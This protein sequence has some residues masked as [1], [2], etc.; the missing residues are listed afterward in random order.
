[1]RRIHIRQQR[2]VVHR[3]AV[4]TRKCRALHCV[5]SEYLPH[6]KHRRKRI[7]EN[8]V[9]HPLRQ[10]GHRDFDA[11]GKAR[12]QSFTLFVNLVLQMR[13][14]RKQRGTVKKIL[15]QVRRHVQR[16]KRKRRDKIHGIVYI[17]TLRIIHRRMLV[18]PA[19]HLLRRVFRFVHDWLG[20]RDIC[21]N[22]VQRVQ[23]QRAPIVAHVFFQYGA[24][25][26]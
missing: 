13:V 20:V 14:H 17:P 1:M 24:Q 16:I 6:R 8:A 21:F 19:S 25:N 23:I 5:Q 3:L 12:G 18:I 10:K 11:V 2:R 4:L 9:A 22:R 15:R 7:N 26:A